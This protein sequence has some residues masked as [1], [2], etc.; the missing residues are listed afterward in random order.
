MRD[1]KIGVH[2]GVADASTMLS[3]IEQADGAG[4]DMAWSTVGGIAP[5]PLVVFTHAALRTDRIG[6]GTSI[7]PT[8]PRHPIALAQ[9]AMALEQLSPGRLRLG[10]GPSHDSIVEGIY[11]IPFDRPQAHLREYIAILRAVLETGEVDFEGELL[12]ARG[13]ISAPTP[14]PILAG[15]LR[16]RA[17]R[18]CGELTDGAISWMCPLPYIR[19][20]AL[21]ALAEGAEGAGRPRPP[22]VAHMPVVVWDDR[23][24]VRAGAAEGFGL[25][26]GWHY[27][28]RMMIEAGLEDARGDVFTDAMVDALIISGNEDEVEARI[29]GMPDF[30]ASELLADICPVGADSARASDRT[31]GLLG[32]VAQ[33]D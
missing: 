7:V 15:A 5:D 33:T 26:Q 4:L 21:P 9:A 20:T 22:L 27:Y 28:Q 19:D 2:L 23:D 11:G 8:Y 3:R 29:R 10:I 25:Y 18:L 1:F 16:P 17:F 30:G 6:L 12:R 32:A 14:V 13:Q 31:I 24:T